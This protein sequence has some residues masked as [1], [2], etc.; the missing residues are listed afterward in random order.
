MM[1]VLTA[2]AAISMLASASFAGG[3]VVVI[4][5]GE[6][7]VVTKPGSQGIL[8]LLAGAVIICAIACGGSDDDSSSSTSE[9]VAQ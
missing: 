3:P 5:E 8:P 6:P 1:K 9:P 7:T 4:D 2:A